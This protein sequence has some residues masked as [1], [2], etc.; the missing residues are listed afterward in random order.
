VQ[1]GLLLWSFMVFMVENKISLS[2]DFETDLFS[3]DNFFYDFELLTNFTPYV[4]LQNGGQSQ[5]GVIFFS[6]IK[7]QVPD[8]EI[9]EN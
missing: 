6:F 4:F 8:K 7:Y 9:S 1:T 2:R 5:C 3:S